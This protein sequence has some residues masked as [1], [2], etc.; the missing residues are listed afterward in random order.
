MGKIDTDYKRR[1]WK[2]EVKLLN[3]RK[4]WLSPFNDSVTYDQWKL[5]SRIVGAGKQNCQNSARNLSNPESPNFELPTPEN[6]QILNCQIL[7]IQI[8]NRQN[9]SCQI[10]NI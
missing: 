6:R 3:M 4:P 1:V 7:N 9:S 10:L 2:I 5:D 8:S